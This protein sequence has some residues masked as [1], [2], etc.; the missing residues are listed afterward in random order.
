MRIIPLSFLSVR[1]GDDELEREIVDKSDGPA[2]VLK[3]KE[4]AEKVKRIIN[5]LP[6]KYREVFMLRQI[7]DMSYDEIAEITGLPIGT[8]ENRLFRAKKLLVNNKELMKEYNDKE[9]RHERE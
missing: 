2:E 8:V 7:E 6:E 3:K 1:T 4:S 5:S 9:G